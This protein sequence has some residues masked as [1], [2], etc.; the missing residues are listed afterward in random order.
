MENNHVLY[1]FGAGASANAIPV[2]DGIPDDM[3]KVADELEEWYKEHQSEIREEKRVREIQTALRELADT[4]KN[5][6]RGITVDEHISRLY[7]NRRINPSSGEQYKERKGILATYILLRQFFNAHEDIKMDWRYGDW[8]REIAGDGKRA[9]FAK[10]IRFLTWNYDM[11]MELAYHQHFFNDNVKGW[12]PCV[13]LNDFSYPK[14]FQFHAEQPPSPQLGIHLNGVAR[15]IDEFGGIARDFV[16]TVNDFCNHILRRYSTKD[17]SSWSEK[18]IGVLRSLLSYGGTLQFH[19]EVQDA[20]ELKEQIRTMLEKVVCMV[21][22]GYSFPMYNQRMDNFIIDCVK[23]KGKDFKI[24]IQ[25]PEAKEVA[26]KVIQRFELS[27]ENIVPI[28]GIKDF[29]TPNFLIV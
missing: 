23:K 29:H 7:N 15:F 16:L 28:T 3:K 12:A 21:V 5:S 24:Y 19:W 13:T 25:D 27:K 18:G 17:K 22:V 10:K 1:L 20:K 11:Q 9:E 26:E 2:V 4:V 6:E 8:L 14:V